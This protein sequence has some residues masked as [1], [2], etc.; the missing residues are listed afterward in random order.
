MSIPLISGREFT[1]ADSATAPKVAI[2][3]E[4]FV[5]HYLAKTNPIG[6]RMAVGGNRAGK[7]LDIEIV[8][9]PPAPSTR[10]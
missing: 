6:A 4:A 2:V 5:K 1:A 9:V 10:M 7:D 3:N 8:G